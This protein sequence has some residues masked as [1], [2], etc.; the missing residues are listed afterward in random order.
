MI[1]FSLSPN[2]E[3]IQIRP[4]IHY[5]NKCQQWVSE[6]ALLIVVQIN[7][8]EWTRIPC[9]GP[10]INDEEGTISTMH[11]TLLQILQAIYW[12]VGTVKKISFK[13]SYLI[14]WGDQA[15]ILLKTLIKS[16]QYHFACMMNYCHYMTVISTIDVNFYP[17]L[18]NFY[19][20]TFI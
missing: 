9:S 3:T 4:V 10:E 8:Q 17:I 5:P 6:L 18:I 11:H 20:H 1:I 15:V 19:N 7:R 12:S 13:L 2:F 16:L 14:S